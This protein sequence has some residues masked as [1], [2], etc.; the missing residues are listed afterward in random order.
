MAYSSLK[1]R[2]GRFKPSTLKPGRPSDHSRDAKT[3][4]FRDATL[5][6]AWKC[7]R[8]CVA[9]AGPFVYSLIT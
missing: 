4:F 3:F 5:G 2:F 7:R 9:G 8:L 1:L 6:A